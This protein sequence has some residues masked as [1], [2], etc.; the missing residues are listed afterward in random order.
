MA[1]EIPTRDATQ[2]LVVEK[3]QNPSEYWPLAVH[4]SPP[5]ESYSKGGDCILLPVSEKSFVLLDS[6]YKNTAFNILDTLIDTG[7]TIEGVILT[8]QDN[9]HTG[10]FSTLLKLIHLQ[11]KEDN[12]QKPDNMSNG[13]KVIGGWPQGMDEKRKGVVKNLIMNI[14]WVA[15]TSFKDPFKGVLHKPGKQAEAQGGEKEKKEEGKEK[16]EEKERKKIALNNRMVWLGGSLHANRLVVYEGEEASMFIFKITQGRVTSFCRGVPS[17]NAPQKNFTKVWYF[18]DVEEFGAANDESPQALL[19][20]ETKVVPLSTFPSIENDCKLTVTL[21]P[22]QGQNNPVLDK[23][24]I[25]LKISQ[26]VNTNVALDILPSSNAEEGH[27]PNVPPAMQ[28]SNNISSDNESIDSTGS[29][30]LSRKEVEPPEIDSDNESSLLTLYRGGKEKGFYY[31]FTGDSSFENFKK[32]IRF[33]PRNIDHLEQLAKGCGY[34]MIKGE[35]QKKGM[36]AKDVL[37]SKDYEH[38]YKTFFGWG[39]ESAIAKAEAE[40]YWETS[41]LVPPWEHF[42]C[43]FDLIQ[44]P[45]HGSLKSL[46]AGP[47]EVKELKF[48]KQNQ[49][50]PPKNESQENE[51]PKFGT[52][53]G[54]INGV[55]ELFIVPGSVLKHLS[56]E[57]AEEIQAGWR[58]GNLARSLMELEDQIKVAIE[59]GGTPRNI[60]SLVLKKSR[61][62]IYAMMQ[63]KTQVTG[64]LEYEIKIPIDEQKNR[65]LL[66]KVD[67]TFGDTLY[68]QIDDM[69]Q[70]LLAVQKMKDL[71]KL[72]KGLFI[73]RPPGATGLKEIAQLLVILE[74]GNVIQTIVSTY[75]FPGPDPHWTFE[76]LFPR[77]DYKTLTNPALYREIHCPTW[78]KWDLW[79]AADRFAQL[80]NPRRYQS[81]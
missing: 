39:E 51:K 3:N 37:T 29:I 12:P 72:A 64:I 49:G 28:P 27:N 24:E 67:I 71:Y 31:L 30:K 50:R 14:K 47:K 79:E 62:V 2:D 21:H 35:P 11:W 63:I 70:Q 45:H 1:K 77:S 66:K 4:L 54:F 9:D 10:G 55:S 16:E 22:I 65:E 53:G 25:H 60:K 44:V 20:T 17:K 32:Q 61:L 18:G 69:L 13:G 33:V 52:L 78:A 38:I 6:G 5:G 56:Y 23:R 15:F 80:M 68:T 81:Y 19:R 46:G 7:K 34:E 42:E 41:A 59:G 26:P 43:E 76:C 58:P 40:R 73:S 8:H 74:E 36:P 48:G 75:D 57:Y